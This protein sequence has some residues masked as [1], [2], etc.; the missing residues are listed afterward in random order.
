M[1]RECAWTG[2][3]GRLPHWM[4]AGSCDIEGG[5]KQG[6]RGER[7]RRAKPAT[8]VSLAQ[9]PFPVWEGRATRT[10]V[11]SKYTKSN[12]THSLINPRPVQRRFAA[13]SRFRRNC[14]AFASSAVHHSVFHAGVELLRAK[15]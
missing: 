6:P 7:E 11:S 12:D 3:H 14:V 1:P 15:R 4:D 8:S 10:L 9:S 5:E 13:G 2:R